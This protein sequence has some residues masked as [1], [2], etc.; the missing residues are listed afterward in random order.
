MARTAMARSQACAWRQGVVKSMAPATLFAIECS[1]ETHGPKVIDGGST[2]A[3]HNERQAVRQ[4]SKSHRRR[5]RRGGAQLAGRC[6]EYGHTQLHA[7]QPHRMD[8]W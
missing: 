7:R 6:G 3:A 5:R 2:D 4:S 8:R 1:P